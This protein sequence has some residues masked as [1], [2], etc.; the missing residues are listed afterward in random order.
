MSTIISVVVVILAAWALYHTIA[1]M[2]Q[3]KR[4]DRLEEKIENIKADV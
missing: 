3:D 2:Q 1:E 4:I